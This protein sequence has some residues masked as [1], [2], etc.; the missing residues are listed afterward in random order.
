MKKI[1]FLE[2]NVSV[3]SIYGDLKRLLTPITYKMLTAQLKELE[4]DGLILRK[5]FQ[6]IPLKVEYS[7]SENGRALQ[8]IVKEMYNWLNKYNIK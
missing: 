4:K 3:K 5:D 8:P 2:S 6:E 7:M 1:S